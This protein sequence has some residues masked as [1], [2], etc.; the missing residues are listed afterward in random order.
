M[1][2]PCVF[3]RLYTKNN[4]LGKGDV[5]VYIYLFGILDQLSRF[6]VE[7]SDELVMV[8]L[9][10]DLIEHLRSYNGSNPCALVFQQPLPADVLKALNLCF[11]EL[12]LISADDAEEQLKQLRDRVYTINKSFSVNV[13]NVHYLECRKR[14]LLVY[15]QDYHRSVT[16][17]IGKLPFDRLKRHG[18]VRC[19]E[20]FAVNL[21]HVKELIPGAFVTEKGCIVPISRTYSPQMTKYRK[22]F[23]GNTSRQKE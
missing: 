4:Y 6:A 11:P 2:R 14:K 20:S 22:A 15:F 8:S 3:Y 16:H 21:N 10:A 5:S 17:Q 19:H 1:L 18:I 9:I 12:V 23:R 13:K 7:S